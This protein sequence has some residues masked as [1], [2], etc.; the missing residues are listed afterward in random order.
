MVHDGP[1]VD[2]DICR[3]TYKGRPR[4]IFANT[5]RRFNNCG[6]T[7]RL[8]GVRILLDTVTSPDYIVF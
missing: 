5:D 6:N 4:L 7:P 1:S 3:D 2:F 8:E